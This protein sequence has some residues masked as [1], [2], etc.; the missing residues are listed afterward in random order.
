MTKITRKQALANIK[1]AG[2]E[3]DK[4]ALVRIY[5]E[6]RITYAAALQAYAEGARL[7]IKQEAAA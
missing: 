1:T 3:G 2:I 7:R 4:V 6:N 5:T